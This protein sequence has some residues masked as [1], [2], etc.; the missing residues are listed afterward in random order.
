MLSTVRT[1]QPGPSARGSDIRERLNRV[2]AAVV[3]GHVGGPDRAVNTV[4]QFGKHHS[5][6]GGFMNH[7]Q[8][9]S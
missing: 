1:L 6:W 2:R 9:A 5:D 4:R 7:G 3:A 8:I